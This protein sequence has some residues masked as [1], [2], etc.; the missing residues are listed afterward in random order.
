MSIPSPIRLR[1]PGWRRIVISLLVIGLGLLSAQA[2]QRID[3]DL[4][5][6]Y[7]EYTLAATDLA[8]VLADVMRYRTTIIRALE[9]PSQR[10]FERLTVSLPDQRVRILSAVDRFAAAGL[11]VSHGGRSESQDVQAVRVSLDAYFSAAD[12]TL[13]LLRQVWRADSP[14][15]AAKLRNEAERHAADNAGAKLVE[16]TL[17]LDRLLETVAD[18]GKDLRGEGMGMVRM[19][20]LALLI[21]SFLVATLNLLMNRPQTNLI[22][23]QATPF[24]PSTNL[25][26]AGMGTGTGTHSLLPDVRVP[27][28]PQRE[29]E[30]QSSSGSATA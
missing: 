4:R 17:A 24:G 5:V 14:Q 10:D 28:P 1:L 2:L 19:T 25:A 6:I 26:S 11:R 3:Q 27:E 23:V 16:V 18:V 8:H 22:P 20:S 9:A 21:G 15:E 30:E 12:Q 13:R 7:T 29:K